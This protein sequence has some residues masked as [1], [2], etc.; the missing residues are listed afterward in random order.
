MP[1]AAVGDPL[2]AAQHYPR[3]NDLAL[4]DA[5]QKHA[6]PAGNRSKLDTL[7]SSLNGDDYNAL[8]VALRNPAMSPVGIAAAL[9]AEYPGCGITESIV[10]KWR[11]R[12]I[13]VNGL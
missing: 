9:R 13:E 11:A 8:A 1:S 7:L 6:V 10:R 12:N 5:L 3:S 2:A 4:A